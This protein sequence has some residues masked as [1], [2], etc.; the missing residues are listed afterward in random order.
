MPNE[1][2]YPVE[3]PFMVFEPVWISSEKHLETFSKIVGSASVLSKAFGVYEFPSG[4]PRIRL[5][6]GLPLMTFPLVMF[7]SGRLQVEDGAVR[8]EPKPQR[9]TPIKTRLHMRN[10]FRFELRA[11]DIV[12]V[13]PYEH[14]SPF[15]QYYSMPYSRIRTRLDGDLADFLVCVGGSGP[16]MENIRERNVLLSRELHA[17]FPGA[18]GSTGRQSSA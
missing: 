17:A 10:D 13:E 9:W 1:D 2:P 12:S 4:F 6:F 18:A 5:L 14:E 7:A 8:F 16:F 11:A 15:I 3:G